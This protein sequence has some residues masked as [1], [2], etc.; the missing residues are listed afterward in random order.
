MFSIWQPGSATL[1]EIPVHASDGSSLS[2]RARPRGESA[3]IIHSVCAHADDPLA[4]PLSDTGEDPLHRRNRT[5]GGTQEKTA[6]RPILGRLTG[7]RTPITDITTRR[8]RQSFS[9]VNQKKSGITRCGA[10]SR[11]PSGAPVAELI[12]AQSRGGVCSGRKSQVTKQH[13]ATLASQHM[14]RN[15]GDCATA[16]AGPPGGSGPRHRRRPTGTGR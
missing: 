3:P 13:S 2:R 4:V 9:N 5:D 7:L 11:F 16:A 8:I 14:R 12:L 15:I 10:G 6:P 1:P